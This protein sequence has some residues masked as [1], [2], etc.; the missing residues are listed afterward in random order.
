MSV[1]HTQNLSTL[2]EKIEYLLNEKSNIL[3]EELRMTNE[4]LNK[5]KTNC[6][7]YYSDNPD[8]NQTCKKHTLVSKNY[9]SIT[10]VGFMIFIPLF[11]V[12]VFS[13]NGLNLDM[14]TYK[15]NNVNAIQ[16][17]DNSDVKSF[18]TKYLVQNLK[19]DVI[20]TWNYWDIPAGR[21][22]YVSVIGAN[23]INSDY[24]GNLESA[25]LSEE[26]ITFDKSLFYKVP[27][28]TDAEYYSGWKGA[29][30]NISTTKFT[31]PSDFQIISPKNS[32]HSADIIITLTTQRD[33]QGIS[34]YTKSLL[35]GNNI[36]KSYI[37]IYE[38]DKLSKN[39]LSTIL[40]HEFGHALGLAH[41]TADEDL[42][43]PVITTSIPFISECN[44]AAI[45]SLYDGNRQNEVTCEI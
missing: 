25:I 12:F 38:V 23:L 15:D 35:E 34:G 10:F 14:I 9:K 26:K 3:A 31:I 29:L 18:D 27:K 6:K 30:D 17:N 2:D 8:I 39:Q 45:R 4:V 41:S 21:S 20:D 44:V 43:A 32:Q 37:T 19:G 7:E 5:I 24:Y 36:L 22:L 28:G 16:L 11:F 13:S 40:R 42:M 33:P 1:I